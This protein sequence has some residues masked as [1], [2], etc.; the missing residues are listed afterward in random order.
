MGGHIRGNSRRFGFFCFV[1]Y[2]GIGGP[3]Y[4]VELYLHYEGDGTHSFLTLCLV[5]EGL[6]WVCLVRTYMNV[7]IIDPLT[8]EPRPSYPSRQE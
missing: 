7:G 1:V 5:G 8:F 6:G 3:V 4:S 2:E